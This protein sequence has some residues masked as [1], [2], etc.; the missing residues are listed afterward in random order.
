[1]RT[2]KEASIRA[3]RLN[4]SARS[5]DRMLVQS[6]ASGCHCAEVMM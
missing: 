6:R 1:V 5:M 3:S 2:E 4:G